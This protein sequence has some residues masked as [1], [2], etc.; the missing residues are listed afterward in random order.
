MCALFPDGP[1]P[2]SAPAVNEF[3]AGRGAGRD[4]PDLT[5]EML[6]EGC[7]AVHETATRKET[8]TKLNLFQ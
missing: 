2:R 3:C 5:I 7:G 1:A 6:T 4:Q 8:E